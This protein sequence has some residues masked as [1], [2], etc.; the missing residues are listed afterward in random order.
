VMGPG[1]SQEAGETQDGLHVWEDHFLPEVIDPVTLEVLPEGEEGEL[2]FTSLTKQAMPVIRY[3]TR[4]L[5]RLLPGTARTMRRME[6]VTGRT[7]DMIILRGVNLF[8]TQIEELLLTLPA[9]SPHFQCVLSR[10]GN[11]DD[12]TV[13]VERRE[14]TPAGSAA[15][16]GAALQRLVK[17]SIG[18]TVQ[19]DVV[20]P[21]GVERSVGKMRRIVDRRPAR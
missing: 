6:K 4:D 16:A 1:V 10:S 11:L 5:T 2:V 3:R 13:L 19:V 9:L 7:D 17:N 8:P 12:L 18:V 14:S 20:E 15:E 21:D